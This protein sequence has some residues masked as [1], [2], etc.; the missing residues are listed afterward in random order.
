MPHPCS[1]EQAGTGESAS[2]SRD[3]DTVRG[4]LH[5]RQEVLLVSLG[6]GSHLSIGEEREGALSQVVELVGPAVSA[7]VSHGVVHP[8]GVLSTISVLIVVI[9]PEAVSQQLSVH[10]RVERILRHVENVQSRQDVAAGELLL[11]EVL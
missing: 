1:D 5:F 2:G 11:G 10:A 3:A 4:L 8:E 9:G 6:I 7:S